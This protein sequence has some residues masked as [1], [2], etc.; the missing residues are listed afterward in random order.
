MKQASSNQLANNHGMSRHQHGG[1]GGCRRKEKWR[2]AQ[3]INNGSANEEN[4]RRKAK[5]A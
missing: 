1:N 5:P 2:S 3:R 4:I